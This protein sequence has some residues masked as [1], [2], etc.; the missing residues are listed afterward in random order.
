MAEAKSPVDHFN[1]FATLV[2]DYA[3]QET[4]DPLKNLGRY[5]G[6]GLAGSVSFGVGVVFLLLALLRGLQSLSVFDQD[7]LEPGSTTIAPYAITMLVGLAIAGIFAMMISRDS[8]KR[9]ADR[10]GSRS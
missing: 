2:K 9:A 10:E 6:F 7:G 3:K 1:E 5:L 8:K 4:V